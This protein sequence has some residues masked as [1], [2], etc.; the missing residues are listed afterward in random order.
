MVS[1]AIQ[2][3]LSKFNERLQQ[4]TSKLNT[5]LQNLDKFEEIAQSLL[6]SHYN[7]NNIYVKELHRMF[8]GDSGI[9]IVE[10]FLSNRYQA[11]FIFAVKFFVTIYK[12]KSFKTQYDYFKHIEDEMMEYLKL[13]NQSNEFIQ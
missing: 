6:D 11:A 7:D 12:V 2:N 4:E 5:T 9:N 3:D 10:L 13:Q 1:N 8:Y